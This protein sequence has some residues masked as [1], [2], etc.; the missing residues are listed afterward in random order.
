MGCIA[1]I[2]GVIQVWR[3]ARQEIRETTYVIV[4]PSLSR[5]TGHASLANAADLPVVKSAETAPLQASYFKLRNQV[6]RWGPDALPSAPAA[7]AV[8]P[9]LTLSQLLG[10]PPPA[11]ESPSWF[12]RFLKRGEPL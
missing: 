8:E 4:E 7:V 12:H 9:P 6:L 1:L 5:P 2:L 10:E 3:P 11:A